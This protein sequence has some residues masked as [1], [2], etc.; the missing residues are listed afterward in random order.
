MGTCPFLTPYHA[1]FFFLVLWLEAFS[2]YKA[3]ALSMTKKNLF[4][5]VLPLGVYFPQ[6]PVIKALILLGK[7]CTL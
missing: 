6:S 2:C 1:P 4:E 7:S 5:N 3:Y